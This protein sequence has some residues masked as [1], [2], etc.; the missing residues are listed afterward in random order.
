MSVLSQQQEA[1]ALPLEEDLV[2]LATFVN[3]CLES[4][5]LAAG[6]SVD[7]QAYD[8]PDVAGRDVTDDDDE[9]AKLALPDAPT[10]HLC[11]LLPCRDLP[12]TFGA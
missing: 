6:P 4:T 9:H 10:E 1:S 11:A 2:S 7:G 5:Q 3:E 12:Q 8:E